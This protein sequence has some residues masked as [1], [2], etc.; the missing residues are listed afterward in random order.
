[1]DTEVR[2][3]RYMP[4]YTCAEIQTQRHIP[5]GTHT[6]VHTCRC[7]NKHKYTEIHSH[8]CRHR[9]TQLC[10]HTE[11]ILQRYIHSAAC[12]EVHTCRYIRRDAYLQIHTQRCIH[13]MHTC[14]IQ[15]PDIPRAER[16]GAAQSRAAGRGGTGRRRVGSPRTQPT[17]LPHRASKTIVLNVWFVGSPQR[18]P[19]RSSTQSSALKI[20]GGGFSD[21]RTRRTTKEGGVLRKR[22]EILRRRGG[23]FEEEGV[24]RRT[25][26]LCSFFGAEDRRPPI[27]DLRSRRSKNPPPSS[28]FD[29]RSRRSKNPPIFDL[30]PR[31]VGRRSDGRRG[32]GGTGL[33]FHPV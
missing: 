19:R 24:L 3:Q 25:P 26:L 30:R 8:R 16:F 18:G 2:M 14:R 31:R 21:F 1:M 22:G 15:N 6:E 12:T 20:E 13:Y 28:I 10:I 5:I 29:L 32:G 4:A 33:L 17:L 23:F 11:V 9:V 27:F 7:I